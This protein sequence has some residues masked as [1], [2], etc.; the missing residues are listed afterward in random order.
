MLICEG[1]KM[2]RGVIEI[3]PK[4]DTPPFMCYGDIMIKEGIYYAEGRSFPS[5]IVRIWE[6]YTDDL[7]PIA[8]IWKEYRE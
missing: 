2:F 3:T 1:I 5:E 8:D 7:I 6:D 4:N